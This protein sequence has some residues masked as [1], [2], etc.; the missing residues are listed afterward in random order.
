MRQKSQSSS[1]AIQAIGSSRCF[2]LVVSDQPND[3]SEIA[4]VDRFIILIAACRI[5]A[6]RYRVAQPVL[7]DAMGLYGVGHHAH[8][9][10]LSVKK[11]VAQCFSAIASQEVQLI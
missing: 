10:L 6:I 3:K 1:E 5:R 8:K 11:R 4:A 7:C 2:I 9:C